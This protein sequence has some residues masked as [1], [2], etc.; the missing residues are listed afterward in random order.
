MHGPFQIFSD[1]EIWLHRRPDTEDVFWI[2]VRLSGPLSLLV[3]VQKV[4]IDGNLWSPTDLV[5]LSKIT[6][7][8]VWILYFMSWK[9]QFCLVKGRLFGLF[10]ALGQNMNGSPDQYVETLYFVLFLPQQ[11]WKI[12]S[13]IPGWCEW[14]CKAKQILQCIMFNQM[15]Q[16]CSSK[17]HNSSFNCFYLVLLHTSLR[18]IKIGSDNLY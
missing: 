2:F 11:S 5:Q 4:L 1:S 12:T 15:Y 13:H 3:M 6:F 8:K 10:R 7:E 16:Q 17:L 14:F 18:C 9:K